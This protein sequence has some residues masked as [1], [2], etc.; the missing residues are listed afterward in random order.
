MGSRRR[1][2]GRS[3]EVERQ[4]RGGGEEGGGEKKGEVDE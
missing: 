2:E 3:G 4:G 1:K